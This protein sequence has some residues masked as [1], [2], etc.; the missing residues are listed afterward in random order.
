MS[1][2]LTLSFSDEVHTALMLGSEAEGFEPSGYAVRIIED[3]LMAKD[4]LLDHEAK[5]DILLGR[6]LIEQAVDRALAIV[7]KTGFSSSITFD[8]IQAVSQDEAWLADYRKLVRDE[9]YK[10]GNPRKQT[11][12]QNLGYFIK[13]AVGAKSVTKADNKAA[14]VKVKGSIIQS[15]TPLEL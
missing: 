5:A 3:Y 15:Y 14:N 11:I 12:N 8:T 10:T 2:S 6:S 13:K 4:G 1:K 9:P 7:A